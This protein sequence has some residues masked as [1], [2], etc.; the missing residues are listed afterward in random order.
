MDSTTVL[1]VANI[2][3]VLCTGFMALASWRANQIS[4]RHIDSILNPN[5]IVF[6]ERTP[7]GEEVEYCISMQ[8][9]GASPAYDILAELRPFEEVVGQDEL[10]R[11]LSTILKQ[12]KKVLMPSEKVSWMPTDQVYQSACDAET[13]LL[14]NIRY[15]RSIESSKYTTTSSLISP[16]HDKYQLRNPP[17]VMTE[18][19]W[20]AN[21]I[22]SRLEW[23]SS[24]MPRELK[25][26]E[27]DQA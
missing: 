24:S 27:D 22:I 8:N 3:L 17:G 7:S 12:K 16:S 21:Q 4:R 15:K 26:K 18:M 5:V 11:A 25:I 23:I 1:V 6:F 14:V 2:F 19:K 9:V 13:E 10:R 20:H